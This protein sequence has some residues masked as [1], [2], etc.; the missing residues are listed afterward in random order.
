MN[1]QGNRIIYT[2][3][4]RGLSGSHRMTPR[5]ESEQREAKSVALVNPDRRGSDDPMCSDALGRFCRRKWRAKMAS[6]SDANAGH[7]GDMYRAG[8]QYADI[9]HHHRVL[10]GLGSGSFSPAEGLS[11]A[12][13]EVELLAAREAARIKRADAEGVLRN[14]GPR[15]GLTAI[16][17]LCVDNMDPS[18]YDDDVIAQSLWRLAVHF[19]IQKIGF[20]GEKSLDAEKLRA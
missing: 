4:A 17:R 10:M 13:S 1:A 7:R 11:C 18:P 15:G 8:S 5:E 3:E 16:N 19:G 20:H 2:T 6:G 9:V 14:V 12:R